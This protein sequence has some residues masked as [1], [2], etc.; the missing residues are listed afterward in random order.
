MA[1]ESIGPDP[2]GF[3]VLYGNAKCDG[4]QL[5]TLR[6]PGVGSGLPA[7]QG[8]KCL[9]DSSSAANMTGF[10]GGSVGGGTPAKKGGDPRL[11]GGEGSLKA[12]KLKDLL[13]EMD[14]SEGMIGL[15]KS[16]YY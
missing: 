9:A 10:S 16:V 8:I 11:A 1:P 7:F 14:K 2:G 3:C 15:E 4:N 13:G 5:K 6:F 12:K